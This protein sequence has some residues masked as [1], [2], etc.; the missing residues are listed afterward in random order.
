M[1][2][3]TSGVEL[4]LR[5]ELFCLLFEQQPRSSSL[6]RFFAETYADKLHS[7][8]KRS[9]ILDDALADVSLTQV[10]A[11]DRAYG[12]HAG[13]VFRVFQC[14]GSQC[15][16]GGGHTSLGHWSREVAAEVS[17]G[18]AASLQTTNTNV[19]TAA[20][21]RLSLAT[22]SLLRR[23]VSRSLARSADFRRG[24]RRRQHA[25][26]AARAGRVRRRGAWRARLESR[27][28]L[29]RGKFVVRT[30]SVMQPV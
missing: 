14:R 24:E 23:C 9:I 27:R 29:R 19:V 17:R 25:R 20:R 7:S 30:I 26:R 2:R 1:A 8:L 10:G 15:I 13:G 5:P 16:A 21:Q 4:L 18:A 12:R 6:V 11:V 22:A 28:L 3:G